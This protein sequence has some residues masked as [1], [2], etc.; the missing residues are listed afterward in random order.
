MNWGLG[1]HLG[2]RL[3]LINAFGESQTVMWF[4]WLS[5]GQGS[6]KQFNVALP[7]TLDTLVMDT[8][9]GAAI[10]LMLTMSPSHLQCA[11]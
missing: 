4:E 5:L 9:A 6:N 10:S 7:D 1:R 3:A 8:S 11:H 2:T